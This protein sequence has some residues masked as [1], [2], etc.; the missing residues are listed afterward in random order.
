MKDVE[1]LLDDS[2]ATDGYLIGDDADSYIKD[3]S[4]I[5]FDALQAKFDNGKKNTEVE[6][7]KSAIDRSLAK[8]VEQNPSRTDFRERFEKL[9]EEY[10]SGSLN[11]DI[12]FKAL[13]S[14]TAE[15]NGEE[16]R[17]IRENLSQDELAIFD[18]LTR[19]DMALT[20][21]ETADIKE[22]C[23]NLLNTLKADKLVIDWKK[24]PNTTADV[25]VTIK[26][27]LDNGLPS[28]YEKDVYEVKCHAVYQHVYDSYSGEG[29]SVYESASEP[30]YSA[31]LERHPNCPDCGHELQKVLR[32]M[33]TYDDFH[34]GQYYI[35]G[36]VIDD[37][38]PNEE[39]ACPECDTFVDIAT[40]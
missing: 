21:K 38:T 19:P 6:R 22:V 18:I 26:T 25:D 13:V 16:E 1:T 3:L 34:S 28:K 20:D 39:W 35:A 9:I 31:P 11:I 4:M 7:L 15:L 27:A 23:R 36:C 2:V 5:D 40:N 30:D 29:Y 37:N 10:N 14:F 12:I 8:M 24:R 32:G 33:P 17:H